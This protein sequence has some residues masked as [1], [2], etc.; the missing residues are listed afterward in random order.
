MRRLPPELPDDPTT[1]QVEAW[2]ELAE[3]VG[4]PAFL[5]RVR[6]MTL[7][8]SQQQGPPPFEAGPIVEQVGPAV[9]A[10]W[11]PDSAEGRALVGA[12]DP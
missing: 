3:L 7:A 12:A 5:A 8:G 2:L 1:E 10:V 9:S 11:Q 4:D 6:E